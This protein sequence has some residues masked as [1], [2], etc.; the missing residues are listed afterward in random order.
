MGCAQ[1][2]IEN[3]EAVT[4]CKDRKKLMKDAVTARNAF[5]AAHSAYAMALKNTGAALSDYSHGEFL[6]SSASAAAA[7]AS[8]SSL[9]TAISPPPPTSAAAV[10]NSAASSSS[11]SAAIPQSI[12]DT[13]P[14]PPPPPPLPLQRAA[15][16][17]E[18]NGRSVGGPS[19][20]GLNGIE[21]DGA[22]DHDDDDDDDEESEV[23][24]RDRLIRKSRSR[25]G[26]NRGGRPMIDDHHHHLEEKAPPP[27]PATNSRPTP[28]PRLHQH[29]QQQQQPFYDYF[30]PNV[31]HMPGTTLEDTPPQPPQPEVSKPLPPQ[32][33]SPVTE[34][35]DDDDDDDDDD[36]EEEE[37]EAVETVP[38]RKAPVEERPKRVEEVS[39]ELEKVT[40]LRGMKKSKGMAMAGERRGVRM[41]GT[42]NLG[43]V[44]TELDDNFLKASESA[45]EV[46]KMLEA[47]RLHYHSNFADNR[48]HIDHSARVMRVITWNRSFRGIPNADDG[49]DDVDLEENETHATV[50]DKL[51]AWEKKLYE[52]V[53][54]GELMKI[55]YQ[56]KVAHLNRVKKRGGHSDS[57]E[58]AKAAVSHLHT[59]YIV[60]M[61]S[62]DSTVSEINRLRDEQLY[63]KLLHLVEAMGKMWEMMQMH[64]QRQAE[65]SKVLR[66]LDISQAVKETNDHHHER[67]IQLLAVV[68]EWHTQFCRMIDHQKEYIKALLGWLK[69]NLIPIESTLKEKVSS[70]PRVP[71]PAIHK[72][73]TIWYDRLDKIPDE[74]ARTAIINFAAVISTIMQQQEDEISLRNKCEETRKELGRKIRQFEE[75]YYKYMQKRGPEGMNPDGSE[76][77]NDHKDEVVVRQFNVEQIKKRLEEEEEAYHRQSQQVREKSLASLRTRLPELF[78]AMSEV[79]YSCSDMYRSV[80]YMT[81]RQSQSERHQKPSQGQGS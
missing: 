73:L 53:K 15:T 81:Q 30:F 17:P 29:Q 74:M 60:D 42:T 7:I 61:Q 58:R 14:P 12:P 24:N 50:L 49:K 44:F 9:P 6:V 23:E 19:G 66:S 64:H 27:L 57:L 62:M 46:S 40:N 77:D 8:T 68:Q 41:P 11:S 20:S 70:P 78:Q 32:P 34:E 39:V 67:T 22:L 25:G 48:G 10:S 59:R 51:L 31:E 54:A 35:D 33:R 5:A 26:S 3:E 1:S 45:H 65:I 47:T 38:E 2:K 75:W 80:T 36:E 16:M 18:M 72:L 71:N 63:L 37:E 55:E 28:P 56:K 79:A 21:E 52:E 69:L 13:L 43:N 4:R 76:A